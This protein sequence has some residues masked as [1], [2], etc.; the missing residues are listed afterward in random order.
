MQSGGMQSAAHTPEISF[1]AVSLH[2]SVHHPQ[3]PKPMHTSV[4][5]T[6]STKLRAYTLV[7]STE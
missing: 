5:P 6:D 7:L 2:G 4:M 1:K 3:G